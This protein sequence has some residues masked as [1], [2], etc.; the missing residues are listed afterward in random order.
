[1]CNK[2]KSKAYIIVSPLQ[3]YDGK[4][5][6][7]GAVRCGVCA[8]CTPGKELL[9]FNVHFSPFVLR[10]LVLRKM[11]TK[12]ILHE[13][14]LRSSC[15]S[16]S[17]SDSDSSNRMENLYFK[18]LFFFSFHIIYFQFHCIGCLPQS[19]THTHS[20][21]NN[22]TETRPFLT[23]RLFGFFLFMFF[24]CIPRSLLPR[25]LSHN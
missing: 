12:F 15:F 3:Y 20:Q 8:V 14:R 25:N 5:T 22:G 13:N 4:R 2:P 16:D 17:D 1:M 6:G 24:Y 9:N 19:H 18:L 11:P 10:H 21:T 7:C 23:Y